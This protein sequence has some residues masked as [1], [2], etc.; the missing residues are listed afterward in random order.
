VPLRFWY[1]C[2]PPNPEMLEY[3]NIVEDRLWKIRNCQNIDGVFR[4]LPLFQPPIDPA[5][6]VQA[7][8]AGVDLSSVLG[9]LDSG[10]PPYR[11]RSVHARAS[12]FAGSLRSLGASLLSAIEKRDAEELSRIRSGQELEMLARIREVRV[13]QRDEA[14]SAIAS[15]EAAQDV[16]VQRQTHYLHLLQN[17]LTAEEQQQFDAGE[18]AQKSRSAAQGLQLAA[19]ITSALP[20][21]SVIPPSVSFGGL[22]L[23]NVMNMISAG[24][25]YAATEQDYKAGRA[26]LTGGFYR[27]AQDW[28]LQYDQAELEWKRLEQDLVA[29]R[30]RL[31]IAERELDNH[32]K[33]VAHAEA[34]NTYMRGKFSNL[35]LYDWMSGQLATLYFQAVL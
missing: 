26:G 20:Q 14:S 18:K 30:I 15:I 7:T 9:D 16:A 17:N 21:I 4:Q 8:A 29:A 28:S 19:S 35:E 12:A 11:F 33:Q 31:E 3:W 13:K 24:F 10:L 22:Q 5:L 34:I 2:Y 27:R 6:L 32:A 1:F 25:T 23:A